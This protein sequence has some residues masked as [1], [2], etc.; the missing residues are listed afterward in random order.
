MIDA[1]VSRESPAIVFV[2]PAAGG[3]RACAHLPQVRKVFARHGF[4]AEVVFTSCAQQLESRAAEAIAAGRR[5]LLAMGGDG[6][7]QGLANAAAKVAQNTP[8]NAVFGSDVLLGVLPVG[9]GN[10]FARALKLPKDPVSATRAILSGRARSV[11]LLRARTA[12]GRERLY[13]GG[14]GVGLDAEA[15][16]HAHKYRRLP[17]RLRYVAAA[18]HAMREFPPLRVRAEFPGSNWPDLE[19]QVLLATALNTPTFGAGVRLA[20]DAKID[21]GLLTAVLVKSLSAAKVLALLPRLAMRGEVPEWCVQ[22]VSA[23]RVRLSTDRPCSFHGDGEIL[24]PTP[25]EIC[26]VPNAIRVLAPA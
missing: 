7:F 25:V 5:V 3:G 24:G 9:G 22:R 8:L 26:I 18:L 17:G 4:H 13:A 2:N 23:P 16:Q 19:S 21:D 6:T 1:L 10:D 12:D 11:D 15:A 14:G 20:P